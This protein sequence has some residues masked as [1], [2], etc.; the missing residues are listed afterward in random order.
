VTRHLQKLIHVGCRELR[1]DGETRRDLQL[2]VTGKDS[3]AD[4]TEADL[5]KMLVELKR[6]GFRPHASGKRRAAER[7]DTRFAHVLWGKL[8]RA[9]VVE[10]SG[11]SGLNAFIRA[12]FEKAWGAAPIDV[13]AMRDA[14]QI[15]AVIQALK[16]MCRRNGIDLDAPR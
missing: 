4:M 13:D 1:L 5:D 6:R 8:V 2:V 7:G 12:R 11:A 3:M 9:G 10:R 15:A 14:E 16:A